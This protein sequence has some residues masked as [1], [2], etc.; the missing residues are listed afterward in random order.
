MVARDDEI[1][2]ILLGKRVKG[3][4][5]GVSLVQAPGFEPG[6]RAWKALVL[7]DYTT[8]AQNGE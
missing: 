8:P 7:P 6:L 4:T 2:K 1:V 5:I 3:E